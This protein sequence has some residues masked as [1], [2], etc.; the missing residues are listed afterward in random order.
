MDKINFITLVPGEIKEKVKNIFGQTDNE[1]FVQMTFSVKT[2]KD[3]S[4]CQ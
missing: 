2:F 1:V 4:K 3:R